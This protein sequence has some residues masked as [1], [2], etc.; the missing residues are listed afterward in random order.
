MAE[1]TASPTSTTPAA[2]GAIP[3]RHELP[4]EMTWDLA[5]VFPDD[6]AWEQA[7]GAAE[8]RL[9]EMA[10]HRGRLASSGEALLAALTLRD[11]LYQAIGRVLVWAGLRFSE[12]AGNQR[13]AAAADRAGGLRSRFAAAVAWVDTEILDVPADQVATWVEGTTGL[14]VY[15]HAIRRV[16]DRRDHILP[17]ETEELLARVSDALNTPGTVHTILEDNDLP[18]GTV[19]GE[20][21]ETVPLSQG[22]VERYL[23]SRDARVRRETWDTAADAYL[24]FADTFAAAYGGSVKRDVFYANTRGYGSALEAALAPNQIPVEVFQTLVDTVRANYPTWQRYFRVR[25]RFLGVETLTPGDLAAPLATDAPRIP[26]AEGVELVLASLAPMGETYV[27]INRRGIADRW[28]DVLPNQGK[29]GGAFSG[30]TKGTFPFI[31]MNHHDDIESVSTLT[32]ELGH[33]LHTYHA[34]RSRPMAYWP[35]SMFTAETASNLHQALLGRY[36][37]DRD[38]GWDWTV[39]V[40]EERMSN[41]LRYLFTMPILARFELDCHARVERGEALTAGQ[42]GETLAGFYA[43]GYGD[44]VRFDPVRTGITWARFSHL[45]TPFYVFQYGTGIAAASALAEKIVTD[46]EPALARYIA[47]LEA[48]GDGYPIDLLAEAGIDMRSPEPVERAFALLASYVDRLETL[49]AE[50]GL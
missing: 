38:A 45:Y 43:E 25:R 49:A 47:L 12:D 11:D 35:Y 31:S 2:T 29:G 50:R 30:G 26:F 46:G 42:M 39:T 19:S 37:L 17:A 24:G 18:F 34:T 27:E 9:A 14:A 21:G 5:S 23:A 36:L 33:S 44:A 22:N 28:V 1:T 20:A 15:R 48:G 8:A 7:F 16:H 3:A 41:F 13:Y 4:V 10:A 40:L 32:H 6:A